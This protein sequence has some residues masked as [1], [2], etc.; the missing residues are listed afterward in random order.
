MLVQRHA[1]LVRFFVVLALIAIAVPAFAWGPHSQITQAALDVLGP[2]DPLAKH[3]GPSFA[4]L[5]SYC[6]MGDWQRW[7]LKEP[8]G[9]IYYADD[10]LIFP[11]QPKHSAHV[12]PG[13]MTS[14][15]PYFRRSVQAL[16]TETPA[17]AARWI[18]ALLH[19][20]EDA[21]APP[22]AQPGLADHSKM[23]NWID[24]TKIGIAGYRPQLLGRTED[25]ALAAFKK[26][27]EG[28]V[29]FSKARAEK[30]A[31]L[32]K[33]DDRP[34]VEPLGLECANECSRV[35]ADLL[36]TLGQISLNPVPDSAT[37]RGTI[38]TKADAPVDGRLAKIVIDG[39]NYSTLTDAAGRYEFRN[40][41]A[42]SYTGRVFY[43]GCRM[44]NFT[45]KLEPGQA[46]TINVLMVTLKPVQN[47]LRNPDLR[48]RWVKPDAPDT[49]FKSNVGWES[50]VVP[51]TPG[52]KY[53]LNIQWKYG[54]KG[55]AVVRW[56]TKSSPALPDSKEELPVTE[57]QTDTVF[58][59]PEKMVSA[60]VI[61][62]TEG[63][64][65]DVCDAVS[66]SWVKEK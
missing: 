50:A 66:F 1:G 43:P 35:S 18:G 23:E 10:Y 5:T 36:Y 34:A 11:G 22:H 47:L 44:D 51:V 55:T 61:I 41:P 16:R 48:V 4:R 7:F 38:K 25:E 65:T 59:A 40:L 33:A 42:G 52:Q 19:F 62:K 56:H 30:M 63:P 53:A 24:K 14:M 49:W 60:C 37:I 21:G 17:N 20:T 2:N 45:V 31:P 27:M 32:V 64:V 46:R 8:D 15:E 58:T 28:L 29:A 54:V 57:A 13:V 6:L 3:L 12:M 26:R 39:T 9:T